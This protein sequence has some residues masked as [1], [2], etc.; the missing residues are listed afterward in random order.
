MYTPIMDPS[1]AMT[2]NRLHPAPSFTSNYIHHLIPPRLPPAPSPRLPGPT[3]PP[4][5]PPVSLR[6]SPISPR[7]PPVYPVPILN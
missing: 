1:N 4:G 2:S 3:Y 6:F 7:S 5:L